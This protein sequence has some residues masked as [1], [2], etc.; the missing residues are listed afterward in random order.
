MLKRT[1][2]AAV[3]SSL[4]ARRALGRRRHLRHRIGAL[5]ARGIRVSPLFRAGRQS[6]ER[7]A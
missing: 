6:P 1:S 3:G 2:I 5:L 7:T 4:R